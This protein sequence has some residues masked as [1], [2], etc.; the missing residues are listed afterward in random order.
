MLKIGNIEIKYPVIPAPMAS[1]SDI[2]Y[3]EL[4]DEIGYTGYMVSEMISAEG[5]RRP[6]VA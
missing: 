4:L 5:L 1:F 2:A 3:R 6:L